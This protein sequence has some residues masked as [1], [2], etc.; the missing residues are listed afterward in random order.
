MNFLLIRRATI[1]YIF[2]KGFKIGTNK[3]FFQK[4]MCYM[5]TSDSICLCLF[6]N[7][8][9]GDRNSNQTEFIQY[10]YSPFLPFFP[11]KSKVTFDFFITRFNKVSK[12]MYFF[13]SY[14]GTNF[15]TR[16]NFNPNI[17]TCIN[18]FPYTGKIIMV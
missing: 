16:D 3:S 7:F 14:V 6:H 5:G 9:Y 13:V 12:N 4:S 8:I 17:L 1:P 10:P 11:E 18:S 15:N 2:V